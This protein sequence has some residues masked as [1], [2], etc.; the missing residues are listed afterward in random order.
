MA[1]PK[2]ITVSL[3]RPRVIA[4]SNRA[5]YRLSSL[6]NPPNWLDLK[7]P[8]KS[9]AT[10]L[11]YIWAMLVDHPEDFRSPED[12][13]E[14]VPLDKISDNIKALCAAISQGNELKKAASSTR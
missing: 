14:H 13:A 6:P 1:A 10:L 4:W 12:L 2:P 3:D 5:D 8:A 9:Y 7:N 11:G